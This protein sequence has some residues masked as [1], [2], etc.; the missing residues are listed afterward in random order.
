MG[1]DVCCGFGAL[2]MLC[3][4]KLAATLA[5]IPTGKLFETHPNPE[6]VL[7]PE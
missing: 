2:M 1:Y 6:Y 4:K 5:A 7:T 3:V